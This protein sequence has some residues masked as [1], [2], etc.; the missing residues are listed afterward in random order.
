MKKCR[1]LVA[2]LLIASCATMPQS[3]FAAKITV[4]TSCGVIN[5]VYCHLIPWVYVG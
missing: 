4:G 1:R 3:A 2:G 5:N